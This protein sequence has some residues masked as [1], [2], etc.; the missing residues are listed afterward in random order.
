MCCSDARTQEPPPDVPVQLQ[1][2]AL[3][4]VAS[5]LPSSLESSPESSPGG[6]P[7]GSDYHHTPRWGGMTAFSEHT[8]KHLHK[9]SHPAGPTPK[10]VSCSLV[11]A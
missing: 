2:H 7:R 3:P 4:S 10:G 1:T 9:L 6:T 5:S 8:L 11:C